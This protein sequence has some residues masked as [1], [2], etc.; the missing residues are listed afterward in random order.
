M[1]LFVARLRL[2]PASIQ[3]EACALVAI[4]DVGPAAIQIVLS[5]ALAA[6]WRPRPLAVLDA[7]PAQVR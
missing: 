2:P 1:T 3:T 5:R 7:S 4:E 6:H